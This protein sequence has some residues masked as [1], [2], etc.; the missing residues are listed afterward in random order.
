MIEFG[1]AWDAS[2]FQ[3][4]PIHLWD[5]LFVRMIEFGTAWDASVFKPRTY[6]DT[7]K[8]RSGVWV[9]RLRIYIYTSGGM[10]I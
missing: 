1:T 3:P 10:N 2:V 8:R 7:V 6:A 9:E 4:Q 5:S